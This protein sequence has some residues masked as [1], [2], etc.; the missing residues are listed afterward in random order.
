MIKCIF[1]NIKN[2]H[3]YLEQW[4]NYHIKLGFNKF[5]LYEDEG[6]ESHADII[7]KYKD[8][9]D[10]DFY[11]YVLQKD[12]P[13]FK[14]T[15]CFQHIL[16]NY[17]DIDWIIKLDPDEYISF[18]DGH[19]T[20]DD[21]LYNINANI[22]QLFL[23]W[24]LY[25][26]NG[27][28][29][30]PSLGKY[31]L[32]DT[33]ISYVP[34]KNLATYFDANTSSIIYDTGKALFR[35]SSIKDRQAFKISESLPHYISDTEATKNFDPD[36]LCINHYITKSFDEYYHRLKDKGEYNVNNYRKLGDF[37]VLNPDMIAKIPEI[38][39]KYKIDIFSFQTKLNTATDDN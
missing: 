33:Y 6:S 38:E 39:N 23:Y 8:V 24:R 20:I 35:Y 2:E 7:A 32:I 13:T 29:D 19:T 21:L 5:I 30:C 31:S 22:N 14:D 27:L 26:A 9:T 4:L 15:K 25:N 10:I 36:Y 3:L 18:G 12:D 28:I 11:D 17:N 16:E 34:H 37:F 1:T